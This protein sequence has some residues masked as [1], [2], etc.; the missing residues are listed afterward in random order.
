MGF[1]AFKS[2]AKARISCFQFLTTPRVEGYIPYRIFGGPVFGVVFGFV[3]V[4]GAVVAW[5]MAASTLEARC[6]EVI[7]AALLESMDSKYL[8]AVNRFRHPLSGCGIPA[9]ALQC[10][11][12][13]LARRL[14]DKR[15]FA[16][17]RSGLHARHEFQPEHCETVRAFFASA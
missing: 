13:S 5:Q 16:I 3:G 6:V 2:K 12:T 1:F 4:W 14:V 10:V 17:P 7:A 9:T 15:S 11:M 8:V